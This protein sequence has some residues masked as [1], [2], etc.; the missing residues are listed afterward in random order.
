MFHGSSVGAALLLVILPILLGACI[1]E[2]PLG[3]IIRSDLTEP[4]EIVYLKDGEMDGGRLEPGATRIFT[5]DLYHPGVT[6]KES[7]TTADIVARSLDGKVVARIPPPRCI[8][9][10]TRLSDWQVP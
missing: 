5:F 6:D 10:S 1:E 8:D 7:C 4:V 3:V 2:R 9:T